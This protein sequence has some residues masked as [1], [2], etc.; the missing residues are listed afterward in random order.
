M[1]T[2][3]LFL[4]F[5]FATLLASC[6]K[7][8]EEAAAPEEPVGDQITILA[9]QADARDTKTVLNSD[10]SVF[11]QPGDQIAVFFNSVKVPFTAYNSVDAASALFVGNSFITTG[12]NENSSGNLDGEYV[13][14]GLYPLYPERVNQFNEVIY[15]NNPKLHSGFYSYAFAGD[16]TNRSADFV[17]VNGNAVTTVLFPFQRG[18]ANTFDPFMNISLAK[19][20]DYRELAFYNVL[21]GVRFSVSADNIT[22]VVFKGNADENL[23]GFFTVSMNADGRPEITE[24][25]DEEKEVS[26]ALD[27]N[28]PFTPGVW[29]YAMMFPTQ[30]SQGYTVEM[31]TATNKAVKTV[32]TPVEIKR[33]VFGSLENIDAGVSFDT[34]VVY[35][36]YIH[37]WRGVDYLVVNTSIE[38][39]ASVVP[40]NCTFPVRYYISDPSIASVS[41]EGVLTAHAPGET[42]IMVICDNHYYEG[43]YN[44]Y[45]SW[46]VLR[47]LR[48]DE[49]LSMYVKDEKGHEW[50]G[51]IESTPST[52]EEEKQEEPSEEQQNVVYASLDKTVQL[53]AVLTPSTCTG[54][55][56]WKSTDATILQVDQ[57][58][59]VSCVGKGDAE[60]IASIGEF[61]AHIPFHVSEVHST[62]ITIDGDFS[63]WDNLTAETADGEYNIYEE[64]TN[65]DLTGMLRLK[66]TSDEDNIYVYTE[67]NYDNIYVADGGPYSQGDGWYGFRPT[68]PGTGY[69]LI[70]CV[71]TYDDDR[72]AFAFCN[73]EGSHLWNYSGFDAY[74]AFFFLY[75]LVADRM[76]FGWNDNYWPQ[77]HYGEGFEWGQAI[78]DSDGWWGDEVEGTVASDNTVSDQNTFKFSQIEYV[79]D[80]V[81]DNNVPVI[82]IE[83]AMDR[84]AINEDGTKVIGR[85]VI[86]AFYE[87]FGQEAW[88]LSLDGSGKLPSG[89]K[90]ITLILAD[91]AV[92]PNLP[93]AVDGDF[94]EWD[95]I[96]PVAGDAEL[97]GISIMK[98]HATDASLF[99]YIEADASLL[100][101]EK[102]PFANYL[103]LYLDCNGDGEAGKVTYWDDPEG[104]GVTY[105]KT[106]QIWLMTNGTGAMANWDNGFAGKGKIEEGVYKG[107]FCLGRADNLLKSKVMYFGAMVTDQSVEKNSEGGEEWV[108][109]DTIGICPAQGKSLSRVK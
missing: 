21:G 27:G 47:V 43:R 38:L 51:T 37:N 79:R 94:S 88:G 98:S 100:N 25:L 76:Q 62:S 20:D 44:G 39:W 2:K 7:A 4:A 106:F 53:T 74:H 101:T 105:D 24:V 65:P 9:T 41:T 75:D 107:E 86:G 104:S 11:W 73:N 13:Y 42:F 50:K 23:A 60:V 1:N 32:S 72:G 19:S 52:G 30:L 96:A 109:G 46:S 93:F 40:N 58:G 69:P 8:E 97:K 71:G 61:T 14:W 66:L 36:E 12:H 54:T 35:P 70:V 89:D 59:L 33:S 5:A 22:R 90:P 57:Q 64:N 48:E 87:Q 81:S 92:S 3:H 95:S 16:D 17:K 63:D 77:N 56:V 26:V 91:S 80:P 83:F 10:G 99:F 6:I 108:P 18:K 29:Y 15:N 28:K 102:V 68:H 45:G 82:K 55:V 31:Y 34:P 78:R 84:S 85:A 67:L 49:C 103:T